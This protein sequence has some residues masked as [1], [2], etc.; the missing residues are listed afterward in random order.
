MKKIKKKYYK[1][2]YI[3]VEPNFSISWQK[4]GKTLPPDI[5]ARLRMFVGVLLHNK[6]QLKD[7]N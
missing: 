1:L 6:F 3:P 4:T 5:R 7:S 2:N